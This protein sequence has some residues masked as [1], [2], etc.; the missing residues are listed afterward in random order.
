MQPHTGAIATLIAQLRYDI[1]DQ[2]YKIDSKF[3]DRQYS[4]TLSDVYRKQIIFRVGNIY[5]CFTKVELEVGSD[6]SLQSRMEDK[7]QV[8][9]ISMSKE[10]TF[11]IEHSHTHV[12]ERFK[13]EYDPN[14][15]DIVWIREGRY[16]KENGWRA[17]FEGKYEA[18]YRRSEME[19]TIIADGNRIRSMYRY[20]L[21]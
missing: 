11:R 12:A 7:K 4:V 16:T 1:E 15:P 5:P 21:P 9:Y 19:D 13:L 6:F 14:I 3:N 10:C 8:N 2:Y 20:V 18:R 17:G